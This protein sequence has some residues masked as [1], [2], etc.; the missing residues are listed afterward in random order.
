M[1]T[2]SAPRGITRHEYR[3]VRGWLARVYRTEGGEQ[4]CTRRLF[5]DGVHGGELRALEAAIR[6]HSEQQENAPP[7]VSKRTPGYGYIQRG[8]RSYRAAT[9][10]IRTYPAFVAYF[11][12]ADGRLQSTSWSIDNH[13]EDQA[14]E[15]CESWLAREQASL[16]S[17]TLAEA[18]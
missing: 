6:W 3:K 15:R 14:K 18:G 12:D 13:G 4:K 5:S 8:T 17:A 16:P 7:R 11:W 9:G 10:E 2:F 1:D